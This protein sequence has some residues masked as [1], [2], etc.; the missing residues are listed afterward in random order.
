[1]AHLQNVPR[2]N[3]PATKRPKYKMSQDIRSQLQNVPTTKRPSYKTSQASKRPNPKTSQPQNVPTPKRP[4]Y[5]T[6]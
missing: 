4:K 1:M 6:S 5:K 2:H 3:V